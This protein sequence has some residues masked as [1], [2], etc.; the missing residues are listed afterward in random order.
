MRESEEFLSAGGLDADKLELLEYL[1]EEEGLEEA[2]GDDDRIRPRERGEHLPL[3]FAQQRLWFLDQLDPGSAAFNIAGAL[4]MTGRLDTAALGRSLNEIVRRHESLHT[5]FVASGG[6]PAQV[7]AP[8]PHLALPI[9]EL[10]AATGDERD[11][12]L[13]RLMDEEARKPFDLR[14]SPQLRARLLR[15]SAE[16]HVLL[17]T[18]HHFVSDGWS[19]GV[20]VRELASLYEAYASGKDKSPLEELEIQYADYALWQRE[21]LT[22]GVLDNQLDYW[23]EQLSGDL[24]VLQLPSEKPRSIAGG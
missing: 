11:E 19:V 23:R 5:S 20:M 4:R 10:T 22:G 3:S 2:T 7:V 9:E 21:H 24:P 17:L 6:Q 14:E 16:E 8:A 12:E 1:L 18:M 13:R 15:L